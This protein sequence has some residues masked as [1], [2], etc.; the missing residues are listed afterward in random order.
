[1]KKIFLILLLPAIQVQAQNKFKKH[2]LYAEVLGNGIVLSANY[3]LQL[4]NKPGFGIHAGIGLAGAQPAIPLG[5]TY[6]IK[7]GKQKSF[8]ETGIG[9]T[10]AEKDL[11]DDNKTQLLTNPYQVAFIPSVG[12]RHHTP[13]GLMWKLIYSPFFNKENNEPAFFGASVGWRL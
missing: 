12:Y 2:T 13:Y 5:M 9:I 1:M 4:I 8:I 7:I 3:E 10:L 11:W 6:L